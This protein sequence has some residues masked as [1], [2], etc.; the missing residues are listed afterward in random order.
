MHA[1]S[2]SGAT[3]SSELLLTVGPSSPFARQDFTADSVGESLSGKSEPRDAGAYDE[4]CER[5]SDRDDDGAHQSAG[6]DYQKDPTSAEEIRN[7]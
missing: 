3:V 1:P 7:L 5:L 4:H 6:C 2:P